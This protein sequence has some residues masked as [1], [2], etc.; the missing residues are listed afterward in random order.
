MKLQLP[1]TVETSAM[2]FARQGI[3]Y[4]SE[5]RVPLPDRPIHVFDPA[6]S[7]RWAIDHVKHLAADPLWLEVVAYHAREGWDIAQEAM[8]ELLIEYKQRHQTLPATLVG[9]DISLTAGTIRRPRPG[10]KRADKFWRDCALCVIVARVVQKF[11]LTPTRNSSRTSPRPTAC[12]IVA[13]AAF[14][15]EG[16]VEK[17]WQECDP[18]LKSIVYSMP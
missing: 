17:V 12:A 13:T 10:P 7:R 9:Y 11:G 2:D 4:Y 1:A 6:E 18:R 5:N 8:R 15:E 14:M 3:A 16:T